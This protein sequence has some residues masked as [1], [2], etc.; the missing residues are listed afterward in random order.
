MGFCGV[1][2]RALGSVHLFGYIDL[3]VNAVLWCVP[4]W[5]CGDSV[6]GCRRFFPRLSDFNLRNS[7][8]NRSKYV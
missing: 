3:P 2:T 7:A 1:P 4:S 5:M 8:L 6:E